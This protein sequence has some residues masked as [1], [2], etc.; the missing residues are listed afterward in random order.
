MAAYLMTMTFSPSEMPYD[1]VSRARTLHHDKINGF[2]QARIQDGNPTL[3][4]VDYPH[5]QIYLSR[6]EDAVEVY[7]FSAGEGLRGPIPI[8]PE[9][10]RDLTLLFEEAR[11]SEIVPQTP[12]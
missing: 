9:L 12:F 2:V 11:D 4:L 7:H 6:F 8:S 10:H 5:G 1:L 3:L